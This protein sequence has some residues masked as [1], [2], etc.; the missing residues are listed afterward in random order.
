MNPE[1]ITCIVIFISLLVP[2]VS[3]IWIAKKYGID[4]TISRLIRKFSRENIW[5]I[6]VLSLSAGLLLGH[7]FLCPICDE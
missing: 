5:Y 6:V 2:I 3:D 4:Y 1:L 7:F